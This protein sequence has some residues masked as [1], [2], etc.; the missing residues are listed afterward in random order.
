MTETTIATFATLDAAE[1]RAVIE[2]HPQLSPATDDTVVAILTASDSQE[3]AALAALVSAARDSFRLEKESADAVLRALLPTERLTISN[4][5]LNQIHRDADMRAALAE[6]FG[7][8]SATDVATNAGSRAS[9][10]RALAHGWR[11]DSRVFA[12]PI[13]QQQ[14]RY[15]GFQFGEDGQPLSAVA[16]VIEEL[17][18]VLAPWE[19][20]L[21]FVSDNSRLG[22]ARPVD[23]LSDSAEEVVAAAGALAADMGAP[24]RAGQAA[25]EGRM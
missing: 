9:N 2:A 23:M 10:P 18:P 15:P 12:V 1:G 11:K 14:Q 21:W 22:G 19:L 16:P 4:H 20:A 3:M 25:V 7:L 8:L 24:D 5:V 6:E 13:E 17:G